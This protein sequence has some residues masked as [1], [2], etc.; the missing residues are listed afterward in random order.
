MYDTLRFLAG[1]PVTS[2]T[3]TAIDPHGRALLR[4]DNFVATL[5]YADGS[6]GTADLHLA[7]AQ[8]GPRQGAAR[9]L[10]RRR[11]VR[12]R[13]LHAAVAG[14]RQSRALGGRHRRQGARARDGSPGRR[15]ARRWRSADSGGA[16][17][18]DYRRRRCTS[19][20]C[21][22]GATAP[23]S[24]ESSPSRS[25]SR[26]RRSCRRARARR[27]VRAASPRPARSCGAGAH[28]RCDGVARG[29][30]RGRRRRARRARRLSRPPSSATGAS[31]VAKEA[32]G[33][34]FL[35]RRTRDRAGRRGAHPQ[36]L[37][38]LVGGAGLA[39]GAAP[40]RTVGVA[41]RSDRGGA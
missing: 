8:D 38:A 34:V 18:R 25:E 41:S 33:L 24:H 14:G 23:W 32:G 19:K 30:T 15:A 1:A 3:A 9:G 27:H 2:M 4:N 37:A 20:T 16:A 22:S 35:A 21:C 10:L 6:L 17:V 28:R 11:G 29:A 7:R 31:P 12:A 5:G 26:Q 36:R 40:H 39:V 13:R